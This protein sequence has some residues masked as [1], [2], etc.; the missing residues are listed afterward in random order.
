MNILIV[1]DE[2]L[3]ARRLISLIKELEEN[4]KIIDT[5][6][7][8]EK[9]IAWFKSNDPPD[10]IFLDI[11]LSDGLCFNIFKEIEV[12][13]PVIF[14]TAYDEYSLKAFELNSVDY[15]LKPIKAEKLQQALEKYN[16]LKTS[17]SSSQL[18]FDTKKLIESIQA[19]K[20]EYTSRFLV[21]KGNS[22]I[23]IDVSDIAYFH[24]EDKMVFITTFDNKKYLINNTLDNLEKSLEPKSFFRTARQ[25]LVTAKAIHK[26]H[27]YFNYKLKLDLQPQPETDVIV[28]KARVSDFKEWLTR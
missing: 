12:S 28:S 16:K 13:S 17:F 23:I 26:I 18:N 22:L 7:S 5:I 15:L 25:F 14:T 2:K 21:N 27:N 20:P 9:A 1:E 19:S 4:A 6:E 8:V 3:A 24:A 11:Q 10:L